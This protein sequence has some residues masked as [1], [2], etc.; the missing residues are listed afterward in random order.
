MDPQVCWQPEFICHRVDS[1]KDLIQPGVEWCDLRRL[2]SLDRL[3]LVRLEMEHEPWKTCL[4][5][6]D[7]LAL[8]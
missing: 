2:L 7:L 8:A 3:L 4:C 5:D 6:D 1:V